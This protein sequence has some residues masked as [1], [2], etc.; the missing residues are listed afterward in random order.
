MKRMARVKAKIAE[1][2]APEKFEIVEDEL[3]MGDSQVLIKVVA[4]GV[5]MSE[6][7][8]YKGSYDRFPFRLGHEPAGIVEQVGAEV[9]NFKPGDRVTGLF[10]PGFANYAL[11][12]P[13]RLVKIPDDIPIEY[14]LGEPIKCA[15]TCCRASS[16][17]FGDYVLLVGCGFMGLLTLCGIAGRG[18]G[19]IIAVDF[20]S[21][22]LELAKEFGATITLNPNE[23]D[24]EK[25]VRRI[26]EGRGVEIAIEAVGKPDALEVA[27]RLLRIPRPKFVMLGY[28][29]EPQTIN[30]GYWDNGVVV[31]NPHPGY[32]RDQMEDLRR[33]LQAAI[34]GV[35]PMDRL[36][37]HSFKLEEVGKA[38][39][40]A[41]KHEDGYIKGVVMPCH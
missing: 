12:F 19:E 27:S 24:V 33:G 16:Y 25:E 10:G 35:F 4:C 28:H 9:E 3:E 15:A 31:H 7:F 6:M 18:A 40:M 29:A 20:D 22:R 14:M 30:L 23:V 11:A 26:T 41:K 39:E 5:C 8:V 21:H 13:N 36:I 17:E 2:V 32:S 34:K 38:F 37:T 1:L